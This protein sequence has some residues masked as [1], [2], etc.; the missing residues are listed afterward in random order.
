MKLDFDALEPKDRYKIMSRT[1]IPR[2]IAWIATEGATLN[3]APF[4]Y[5]MSLSSAPPTLIVSVGHKKDGTPKD[6]LA[7]IRATKKCTISMVDEAHLEPMHCTSKPLPPEVSEAEAFGIETERVFADFPPMV[8]GAP[9]AFFCSLFDEID[10]GGKTVP[11]ILRIEKYYVDDRCVKDPQRFDI[12]LDLIARVG[13][14]YA[15]LGE[16]IDPPPIL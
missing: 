2:P 6:T 16:R 4:S 13:A 9:A 3:L 10:L 12:E 15:R 11:L 7:N 14:K 5:F 1:L 8:K